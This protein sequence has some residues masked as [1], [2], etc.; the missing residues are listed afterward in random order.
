MKKLY[1]HFAIFV[2]SYNLQQLSYYAIFLTCATS[3]EKIK[4]NIMIFFTLIL[5][6]KMSVCHRFLFFES[7]FIKIHELLFCEHFSNKFDVNFHQIKNN[8]FH[9]YIEKIT[10]KF[11]KQNV[12]VIIACIVNFFEY[13]FLTKSNFPKSIFRFAFEKIK[14]NQFDQSKTVSQ[15][16]NDETFDVNNLS[17]CC[18]S[19][20][21]L[22]TLTSFDIQ[23]S[24]I[25]IFQM[26]NF[27]FDCLSIVLRRI[28]N[29]II[30]FW[31]IFIWYFFEISLQSKKQ[32]HTLNET[33]F[34]S[35]SVCFWM[36]WLNQTFWFFEFFE[37]FF[38]NSKKTSIVHYSKISLF[39]INFIINRI[40]QTFDSKMPW[41]MMKNEYWNC[42]QW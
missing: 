6:D 3:F 38:L 17:I 20:S 18:F 13:D 15:K 28:E 37:K 33:F 36:R 8:L 42:H 5:I 25:F 24:R 14:T 19:I 34:E 32:W 23:F 26:F 10:N 4:T 16:L 9:N 22:K 29:K 41:L 12:F 7:I 2:W 30:F 27:V 40:F 11:K 39:E 1:H 21:I 31:F 35:K